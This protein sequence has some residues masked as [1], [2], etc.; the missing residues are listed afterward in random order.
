MIGDSVKPAIPTN[1]VK[2][3]GVK[4]LLIARCSP[5]SNIVPILAPAV[6]KIKVPGIIPKKVPRK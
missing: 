1:A 6:A 5:P 4:I 3:V 2:D